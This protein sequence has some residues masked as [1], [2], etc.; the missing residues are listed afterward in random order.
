MVDQGLVGEA[1]F[2]NDEGIKMNDDGEIIKKLFR[3]R[4]K[5]YIN[6]DN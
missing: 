4:Q 6:I 1:V 2:I 3:S 5:K